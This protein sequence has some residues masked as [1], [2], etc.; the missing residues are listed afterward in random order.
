MKMAASRD[1]APCSLVEEEMRTASIIRTVT[2]CTY[3]TSVCFDETIR[4]YI[5]QG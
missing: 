5:S 4:R 2:V 1:I 3:E